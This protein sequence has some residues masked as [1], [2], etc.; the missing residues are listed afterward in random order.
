MAIILATM[1]GNLEQQ[2]HDDIVD[3]DTKAVDKL[4]TK[5]IMN[6]SL[7]DR[8]NIQ[9]EIHGVKCLATEETPELVEEA[10]NQLAYVIEMTPDSEKMAY[11]QSQEPPKDIPEH[12]RI[13]QELHN[14]DPLPYSSYVNDVDFRLRFLRCETFDVPKAAKRMLKF[15]DI[16]LHLFGDYALRRPVRLSDFT[17]EEMRYMRKGRYQVLPNRDRSGRRIMVMFPEHAEQQCPKMIKAKIVFYQNWAIGYKDVESQRKGHVLVV[18]YG[19]LERTSSQKLAYP[20]DDLKSTRLSSI[21]LCSPDTPYFRIR[22]GIAVMRAGNE[23][24]SKLRVHLG[25]SVEL[26]YALQGVGIPA[27]D[28]PISWTG[29]IKIKN[30]VQWMRVRHAIEDYDEQ[31]D[32]T[33]HHPEEPPGSGIV[34]C[35]QPHDV[36]FRKGNSYVAQPGNGKLRATIEELSRG[37]IVKRPKQLAHDIYAERE[38]QRLANSFEYVEKESIGRYLLWNSQKDWWN[39]MTDKEQ[40]CHKLEYM[41]REL[42]KSTSFLSK[43]EVENRSKGQKRSTSCD[44]SSNAT[45][46]SGPTNVPNFAASAPGVINRANCASNTNGNNNP[47]SN[48]IVLS[49]ATTLFRYQ[50]GGMNNDFGLGRCNKKRRNG[51]ALYYDSSDNYHSSEDESEG[52]LM[53]CFGVGFDNCKF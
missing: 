26:Q 2:A 39:E 19:N 40:I 16:A 35:P 49:S 48:A 29:K 30:L 36:L 10:L 47:S 18:W 25:E 4:L 13:L 33:N 6:L 44:S 46:A 32:G 50:D 51:N 8:N 52:G 23:N 7:R 41:I 53:N 5:E 22:R 17:K 14:L 31:N 27:E 28:I 24:R 21:H 12:Q 42:R 38:Q 1:E 37:E 45:A 34:E 15:L 20:F 43:Q 9:E 3:L 11:L